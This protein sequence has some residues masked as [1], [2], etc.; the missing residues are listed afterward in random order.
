[1]IVGGFAKVPTE[2]S[3]SRAS[4]HFIEEIREILK[5]TLFADSSRRIYSHSLQTGPES[6][7]TAQNE[8]VWSYFVL[9]DSVSLRIAK[10]KSASSSM[11]LNSSV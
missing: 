9:H 8:P 1:M 7:S 6:P 11:D 2:E 4:Y 10:R 3:L 5:G